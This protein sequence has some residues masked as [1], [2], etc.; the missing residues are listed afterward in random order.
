MSCPNHNA[1]TKEREDGL[2][3]CLW[4]GFTDNEARLRG[5]LR[6]AMPC[7]RDIVIDHGSAETGQH[8]ADLL[9]RIEDALKEKP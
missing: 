8:W 4:C 3:V 2:R 7:V 9:L 5:L 6:E 1:G